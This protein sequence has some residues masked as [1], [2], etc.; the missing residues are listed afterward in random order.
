MTGSIRRSILSTSDVARLFNVTETTVKR[1]A[2]EGTL[3]CQRT[4]GGHR[5]FEIR[6]VVDFAEENHFEPVGALEISGDDGLESMVQVALLGRDFPVLAAAYVR[7]ALAPEG[8]Q[9][10]PYLSYLYQHRVQIWELH[11]RVI[12][13]AMVEI[14][15]RWSLGEIGINHEHR[16]SCET[17]EALAKLQLQI[18]IKPP[19]G[20]S[21]VSATLGDELHEIG[22]R[23]A[24]YLFE[25]EGWE[26]HYLGS[27]IPPEA[28]TDAIAQRRPDVVC[29]SSTNNAEAD[30]RRDLGIVVDAA[31]DAGAVVLAG[32]NLAPL[33]RQA[34]GVLD[35][36]H[37]SSQ[38]L[39]CYI[40]GFG[41]GSSPCG[42]GMPP[43]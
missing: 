22:L 36:S 17:L 27:R 35:T 19:A 21:V 23:C 39:F 31:K 14:G 30:L 6:N 25:S 20:H 4:P 8:N 32:G 29:I 12:R 28:L 41:R 42:E 38:E 11:D 5:K 18:R 2:D 10:F 3:K 1:W 9:L 40:Q 24:A 34:D 43:A 13:P 16:A 15:N 26:S 7:R 37:N 33:L